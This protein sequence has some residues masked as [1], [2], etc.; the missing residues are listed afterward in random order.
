MRG[1]VREISDGKRGMTYKGEEQYVLD[2][3]RILKMRN[4]ENI[5]RKGENFL[6]NAYEILR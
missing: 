6:T 1:T 3:V 2:L 4:K 5:E